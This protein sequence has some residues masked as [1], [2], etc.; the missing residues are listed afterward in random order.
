MAKPER[1][2]QVIMNVLQA[3]QWAISAW[4]GGVTTDTIVRCWLKSRV[5]RPRYGPFTQTETEDDFHYDL[6][7]QAMQRDIDTLKQ[8]GN[9]HSAMQIGRFINPMEE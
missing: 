6:M 2:S 1:N 8:I 4:E 3:V 7:I 9:I 5:L